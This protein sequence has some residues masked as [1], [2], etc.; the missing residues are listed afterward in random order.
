MTSLNLDNLPS[1]LFDHIMFLLGRDSLES[2]ESCRKVNS[3]WNKRIMNSLWDNPS[4]KWG[5]II[6]RQFESS[7][8]INLPSEEI[9][10][11]A[12][13][14]EADGILPAAVMESLEEK[15]RI[16]LGLGGAPSLQE[17]RCAASLAHKGRLGSVGSLW[18]RG[19][20]SSVPAQ[21]LAPL[22]ACVTW[23]VRIDNVRGCDLVGILESVRSKELDITRQTLDSDKTEALV[24]SMESAVE[25][26]WLG[27]N[28]E[29]L[30][31]ELLTL[32]VA[33]LT[34]YSGQGK[35]RGVQSLQCG[36]NMAA[37]YREE[38]VTWAKSK[39]WVVVD[40]RNF[41]VFALMRH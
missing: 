24:Q 33:T 28:D 21:N 2:L 14:L 31:S 30:E 26:L 9:I 18:L 29:G 15:L 23:L 39:D 8:D 16:K 1:E 37:R 3:A 38:L 25:T 12:V 6:G 7:W 4:K 11:K 36:H 5:P 17:I 19:D 32:N 13:K 20:L 41:A 10:S 27:F 34:Q 40:N 35:C 22:V